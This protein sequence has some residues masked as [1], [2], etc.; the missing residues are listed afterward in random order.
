MLQISLFDPLGNRVN[1]RYHPEDASILTRRTM[2]N[3]REP[4]RS[5]WP[6]YSAFNPFSVALRGPRS[7]S[8]LES[9]LADHPTARTG[10]VHPIAWFDPGAITAELDELLSERASPHPLFCLD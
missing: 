9:F 2:E 4:R 1:G 5:I 7:S 10:D 8:V 3:H 6:A